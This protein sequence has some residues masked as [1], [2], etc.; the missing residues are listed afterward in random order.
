MRAQQTSSFKDIAKVAW[1]NKDRFRYALRIL[2]NGV[3]DGCALG[4]YGVKDWTMTG[5]HL[6]WIRLNLLRLNTI[7]AFNPSIL[8][9]VSN[10]RGKSEG[11]LRKLGRLSV[12]MIRK[13][14]QSGFTQISWQEVITTIS[15]RLRSTVDPDRI[16]FYLVSRGTPNE[17]YY[18]AQKVARFLGT[19]NIDNSARIC[20]AASTTGL[21]HTIGYAA[22]T[23]S[24]KDLIGTNLIVF[25]GSNVANN[26]PVVMKYLH[27]AKKQGTKVIVVNPFREPGMEKY[28]VPSVPESAV[29]GTEIADWFYQIKPS[30]DIPFIN[31]VLKHLI[32]NNWTDDEFISKHTTGWKELVQKLES[33]TFDE[34]E[35]FSGATTQQMLDFAKHYADARS[36]IFV[37]GMGITQHRY[38][39]SNVKAIVNLDLARGMIGRPKSGLMPIRG[40]SGVQG[41]AEVG[42]VPNQ[43]PGGKGLDKEFVDSFSGV[44]GF[45]VPDSR[46]YFASEMID[47]AW[48]GKLDLLYCVGSNLTSVLPDRDY[49]IQ[50]LERIPLRIHHDIVLNPQMFLEPSDTVILLPATTR[51][52]MQ[53]GNTETST[54]RRII[55]NP[56]IPGPRVEGARDE[57]QVLVEIAKLVKPEI[58][59]KIDFSSTRQIREEI[60]RVIKFYD[61][62]QNLR[63][64]GDQ[65]Q[66]GGEHL[67]V[68]GKF[69]TLDGRAHF[70][71]LEPPQKMLP[72]G[73]FQLITRRGK[74]FNSILFSERD[75]LTSTTR[76]Q[77][78]MADEDMQRLGLKNNE[79]ITLRSET[80]E[81]TGN[82]QAGPTFPG[83]LMAH[84]PESNVLT[85]RGVLDAECGIPAYRDTIVQLTQSSQS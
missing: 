22:T 5:I 4:T 8:S 26:Q 61:G 16:A 17:T 83:T 2:R 43:L 30:G 69:A 45:K 39:T 6:C 1:E 85:Q 56:E 48:Q 15:K 25:L 24:Y 71:P 51:Y 47:A 36:T 34:L 23:C 74:Q 18:V 52:E 84:W 35:Q 13:Q 46:G 27:I 33:Q 28:W 49:C 76:N 55:F 59:D 67:C 9:D 79:K 58:A 42:A 38:G 72:E 37:W 44:W 60:A 57:W 32:A 3:C 11:E 82:V 14:G 20:H 81:F 29:L 73:S 80:G 40:H 41:G 21:K 50:A 70:T 31:G 64:M 7:P 65:I 19:N 10:F 53:G 68:D 66:W 62:I 54:E 75:V 63:D 78:I 12:P 77:I